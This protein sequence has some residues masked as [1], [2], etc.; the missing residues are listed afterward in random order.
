MI[1]FKDVENETPALEQFLL[2]IARESGAKKAIMF[3]GSIVNLINSE[4][5][6]S[7]T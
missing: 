1:T 4:E 2:E 3:D 6:S 5:E 7:K